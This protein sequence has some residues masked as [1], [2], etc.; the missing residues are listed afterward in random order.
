MKRMIRVIAVAAVLAVIVAGSL[1]VMT[2]P[3]MAK[4]PGGGGCGGQFCGG[5]AGLPCPE[6]FVCVDNPCDNCNPKTGG[7]DCGGLCRR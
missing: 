3:S 2:S 7:A 1:V 5:F 4:P 6:G